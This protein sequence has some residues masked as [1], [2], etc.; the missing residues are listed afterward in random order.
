MGTSSAKEATYKSV[1]YR[2]FNVAFNEP[3]KDLCDERQAFE[4]IPDRTDWQKEHLGRKDRACNY[5]DELKSKST[6]FICL[7]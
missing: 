1:F 4:N 5:I 2:D 3:R 6:H 7:L